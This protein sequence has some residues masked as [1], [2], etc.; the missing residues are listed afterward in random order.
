MTAMA[1]FSYFKGDVITDGLGV[2]LKRHT[3]YSKDEQPEDIK[4][5]YYTEIDKINPPIEDLPLLSGAYIKTDKDIINKVCSPNT[6][7]NDIEYSFL[8]IWYLIENIYSDKYNY[9]SVPNT[10][11]RN[12]FLRKYW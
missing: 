8:E 10:Q 1:T 3:N 2:R 11:K 12:Y 6:M 4:R 5:Y 9:S 7:C